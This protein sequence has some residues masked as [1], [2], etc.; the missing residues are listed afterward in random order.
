EAGRSNSHR[1]REK[2]QRQNHRFQ[3]IA[4][5][6]PPS[7][8]V[9][10]HSSA[11]G[12]PRGESFSGGRMQSGNRDL[13]RSVFASGSLVP[14]KKWGCPYDLGHR[15][16]ARV[17]FIVTMGS[18]QAPEVLRCVSLYPL[19]GLSSWCWRRPL[20]LRLNPPG[21]VQSAAR[22]WARMGRRFPVRESRCNRLTAG[23]RRSRKPMTMGVSGFRHL[24]GDFMTFAHFMTAGGPTGG[25]TCGWNGASRATS[26]CVCG[27]RNRLRRTA[28]QASRIPSHASTLGA[29]QKG[30]PRTRAGD[31]P[32]SEFPL[33]YPC[34]TSLATGFSSRP[35]PDWSTDPEPPKS[36]VLSPCD[37]RP[38]SCDACHRSMTSPERIND[39]GR[40]DY[41]CL[42][43]LWSWMGTKPPPGWP[44]A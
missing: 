43:T 10:R 6:D 15:R 40:G 5:K 21:R 17:R 16:G 26:R 41:A 39:D 8:Q 42:S 23:V 7:P 29:V 1:E 12:T 34:I 24:P 3:L 22:F 2:K 35:N 9:A 25:E 11:V 20:V 38:Y 33:E 28:L 14:L 18:T 19:L 27:R 30:G 44:T 32:S 4:H 31:R 36:K 37:A 13:H